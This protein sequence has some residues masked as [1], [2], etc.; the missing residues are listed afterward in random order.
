[1]KGVKFDFLLKKKVK[2]LNRL[3]KLQKDK[4]ME[5]KLNGLLI[6]FDFE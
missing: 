5:K 3:L 1:M 4:R 2:K 6:D